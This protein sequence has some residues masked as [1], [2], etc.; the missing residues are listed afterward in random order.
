MKLLLTLVGVFLLLRLQAKLERQLHARRTLHSIVSPLFSYLG[1]LDHE[2]QNETLQ[3]NRLVT[4][5]VLDHVT[6]LRAFLLQP[7]SRDLNLWGTWDWI[8][9]L[10]HILLSLEE[11]LE[12]ALE[13]GLE[14]RLI[15]IKEQVAHLS[16]FMKD[17]PA[18]RKLALTPP[19]IVSQV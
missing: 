15:E 7:L 6:E 13:D 9:R 4:Q 10:N 8:P 3:A 5:A 11:S 18:L 2:L 17:K 16:G 1:L 12:S 19:G 14:D